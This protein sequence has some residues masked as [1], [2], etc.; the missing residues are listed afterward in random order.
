M[1]AI[2]PASL[3]ATTGQLKPAIDKRFVVR[4]DGTVG[5]G[6]DA[7]TQL[8]TLGG[9]EKTRLELARISAS[10]PW[11]STNAAK[12]GDGS[13]AINMQSQGSD[14]PG[15]DFALMRDRR[16]AAGPA[17]NHD[18]RLSSQTGDVIVS[19]NLSEPAKSRSSA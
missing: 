4:D 6:I 18:T 11:S 14:N 15:A 13:F 8:L 10:L 12:N 3:D 2:G 5:V 7:P 16:Q 17:R 1:F 19:I 9:D